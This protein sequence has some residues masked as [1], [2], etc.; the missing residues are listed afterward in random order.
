MP[1]TTIVLNDNDKSNICELK[2]LTALTSMSSVIRFALKF[3]I[4][5]HHQH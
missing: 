2:E 4:R 1:K 3:T 5:N